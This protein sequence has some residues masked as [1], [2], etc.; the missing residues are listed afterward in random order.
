[1]KCQVTSVQIIYED[2]RVSSRYRLLDDAGN[3]LS[4]GV[5][6]TTLSKA[7]QDAVMAETQA[8]LDADLAGLAP[9]PDAKPQVVTDAMN[10]VGNAKTQL[11]AVQAQVAAKERAAADLDA[12]IAAKQAALADTQ[13][14]PAV[15]DKP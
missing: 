3:E 2:N 12:Q 4:R 9:A 14:A 8:E 7:A 6:D 10:A 11:I 13:P 15:V 1:M 5:R